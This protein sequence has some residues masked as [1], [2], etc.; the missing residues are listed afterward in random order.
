MRPMMLSELLKTIAA[1]DIESPSLWIER[2]LT[3]GEAL[4]YRKEI[5][6]IENNEPLV[7][8]RSSNIATFEPHP[9]ITTGAPYAQYS[10]M[11]VRSGVLARLQKAQSLLALVNPEYR[12]K[13]YDAYR[14]LSVQAFMI[15]HEL[16]KL[17]E[18]RGIDSAS[19]DK[20]LQNSLMAEV[21][22]VWAKPDENVSCPP[23]HST[24]GAVDLTIVDRLGNQLNMGSD[25]DA[26]G[27][28]SLPNYF[29]ETENPN[30]QEYHRNRELLCD[31]MTQSGFR[32]LPHEWWH[33]SYGDQMWAMLE[34]LNFPNSNVTAIYGRKE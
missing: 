29:K 6:L 24:G 34:Y 10:P 26:I 18:D 17:I 31:V 32:R 25:I 11:C 9:H 33:F 13:I 19:L 20:S 15:E 14:P 2:T 7:D 3:T 21:L 12:L 4:E 5:E 8:T 23:P 27:P 16:N 1:S 22:M 30:E 28:I